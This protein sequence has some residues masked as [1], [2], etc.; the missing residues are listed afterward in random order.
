M[1]INPETRI[2]SIVIIRYLNRMTFYIAR[3]LQ[4]IGY[5]IIFIEPMGQY[6]SIDEIKKLTKFGLEWHNISNYPGYQMNAHIAVTEEFAEILINEV[7]NQNDFKTLC[8]L[9]DISDF[10][11]KKARALIYD[12]IFNDI[13]KFNYSYALA[14]YFIKKGQKVRIIQTPS[15]THFIVKTFIKN[16]MMFQ[17]LAFITMIVNLS[18]KIITGLNI[19]PKPN[20]PNLLDN[21]EAQR[22]KPSPNFSQPEILYFPHKGIAYGKLFDKDLYFSSEQSSPLHP[23]AIYHIELSQLCTKEEILSIKEDYQRRNLNVEFIEPPAVSFFSNL[24]HLIKLFYSRIGEKA[25]FSKSI[26]LYLTFLR[27][28]SYQIAFAKFKHAKIALLGYEMLFPRPAAAVLQSMGIHIIA[29]QERFL[30]CFQTSNGQFL[31]TYFVH[32]Q[33]PKLQIEQNTIACVK[34]CIISGDPRREKIVQYRPLARQER[35]SQYNNYDQVCLVLDHHSNI[36][37]I[38]N[39]LLNCTNWESNKLFYESILDLAQANTSCV[40]II[41][42]KNN[43]WRNIPAFKEI[44][45][46][47]VDSPNIILD[48]RYDIKDRSYI[49]AA[50]ADIVVARYTSLCDQCLA[51]GI[52]VLVFEPWANGEPIIA[53][54]HDYIPYP[55]LVNSIRELHIR[56]S[57]LIQNEEYMPKS[58]FKKMRRE[59]YAVDKN[60]ASPAQ[61]ITNITNEL[62]KKGN[63]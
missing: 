50:M 41:R 8:Q 22:E 33:V 45:Q 20:K 31:D 26:I 4:L 47:L 6:R 21:P 17:A 11:Q 14:Q 44:E 56:F 39:A 24:R 43:S 36:D 51:N 27:V 2:K 10:N 58:L 63:L 18:L 59:Y 30:S 38:G 60:E 3:L 19:W 49:L 40:F 57:S 9:T 46:F 7:F 23:S 15:F 5:H 34:N 32:G 61:I 53:K 35:Q 55:I 62:I 42:G 29:T 54:W 16:N 28:R 13:Y 48:N 1:N 12:T 25:A 52:P 37:P